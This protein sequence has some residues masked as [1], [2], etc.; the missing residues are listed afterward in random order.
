MALKHVWSMVRPVFFGSGTE[1]PC[2][3]AQKALELY[4]KEEQTERGIQP[5]WGKNIAQGLVKACSKK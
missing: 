2:E 3:E 4:A 5:A 1:K